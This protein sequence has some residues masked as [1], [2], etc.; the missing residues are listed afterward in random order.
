MGN[1]DKVAW[2]RLPGESSK[3]YACFCLYRDMG[4]ERS[5]RRLAQGGECRAHRGQLERWSSRWRWVERCQEYDDYLERQNRFQQEKKRQDM[6]ERHAKLGQVFQDETLRW[7]E[8]F[9]RDCEEGRCALSAA[10]AVRFF[11]LGVKI[12]RRARGELTEVRPGV[13]LDRSPTQLSQE[14]IQAVREALGFHPNPRS[15][16]VID[17]DSRQITPVCQSPGPSNL[18]PDEEED[19][20]G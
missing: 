6:N 7:F 11:D 20:S 9:A 8:K 12:E 19:G 14:S 15:T 13:R 3:A 16:K 4:E 2:E 5:L 10:D 17:A 18:P 1:Q